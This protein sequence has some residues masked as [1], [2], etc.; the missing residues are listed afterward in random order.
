MHH[1]DEKIL[2]SI[3]GGA[4]PIR[5]SFWWHDVIYWR[6]TNDRPGWSSRSVVG[7]AKIFLP[8]ASLSSLMS[9]RGVPGG[10][11]TGTVGSF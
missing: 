2:S 6:G 1:T 3:H 7:L 5:S 11:P 4:H 10:L 8:L 9:L